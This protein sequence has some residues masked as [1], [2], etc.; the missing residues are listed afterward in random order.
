MSYTKLPE[1]SEQA[2]PVATATKLH[3]LVAEDNPDNQLLLQLMLGKVGAVCTLVDNGHKAVERALADEFDL[4][5]MDMQ[6]P[7]MG[8][9]E[10]TRLIRH[11]GIETPIIAVTANVMSEDFERYRRAGCQDLLPKPIMQNEL[12]AI[13]NRF[14]GAKSHADL[15]LEQAL[16]ADP[17]MQALKAQFRMQLPELMQQLQQHFVALHW[18]E[19]AYA[20]HSLKGSAGSMGFPLL[21][22]LAGKLETDA[23]HQ[24]HE[25]CATLLA[26]MCQ[27]ITEST[28]AGN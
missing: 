12:M 8:G 24:R 17:Q 15:A 10:A 4:I 25:S 20:A 9:E 26:Q 5:L 6:M 22:S 14:G 23:N 3:I 13:L 21:T 16:D 7:L 18:R 2:A 19:L 1:D 27:L 28:T 11:A